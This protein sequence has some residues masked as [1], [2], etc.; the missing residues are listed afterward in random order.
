MKNIYHFSFMPKGDVTH[1]TLGAY[2][3]ENL[4]AI[5]S[6]IREKIDS[7]V[8]GFFFLD[9]G[10]PKTSQN[11]SI[12]AVDF[13]DQ[14]EKMIQSKPDLKEGVEDVEIRASFIFD[15][16][17]S[18]VEIWKYQFLDLS[19]TLDK[20][21]TI[22]GDYYEHADIVTQIYDCG[23]YD[24]GII[25]IDM[26]VLEGDTASYLKSENPD[27]FPPDSIFELSTYGL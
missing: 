9:F 17:Y 16:H 20:A 5:R 19:A 21:I 1:E 3:E 8:Q 18:D 23:D 13:K 27:D 7:E 24:T 15:T 25:A 2:I 26:E 6:F 22:Y 12:D 4:I 14:M 11:I 10:V